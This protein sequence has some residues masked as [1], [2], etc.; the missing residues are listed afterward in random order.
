MPQA[1]RL[2]GSRRVPCSGRA[3]ERLWMP[4]SRPARANMTPWRMQRRGRPQARYAERN[5]RTSRR[6]SRS[7]FNVEICLYATPGR[8]PWKHSY[9]IERTMKFACLMYQS[10]GMSRSSLQYPDIKRQMRTIV[11]QSVAEA[12]RN[13]STPPRTMSRPNALNQLLFARCRFVH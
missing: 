1:A 10:V 6:A 5:T 8:S 7:A 13:P 12:R 3:T 4:I 11:T 9:C 2:C